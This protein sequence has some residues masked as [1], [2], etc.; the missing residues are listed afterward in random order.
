MINGKVMT[1]VAVVVVALASLLGLVSGC[2]SKPAAKRTIT[3]G[4]VD[5]YS[6]PPAVYT[7]DVRD[8]FKLAIDKVNKAGTLG[9]TI[10]Y[11]TRDDKFQPDL[12]LSMAKQLV[13]QDKVDI[14]MGTINSASSLAISNYAKTQKIPFIVTFSKSEDITGKDGHR[15]VFEVSENTAMVGKATADYLAKQPYT[16][17]WIAG[18]DYDYGHA[19]ANDTWNNLAALKPGVKLLGQTWWKVGEPDFTPYITAILAAKPDALIVATGGADMASFM[20]AAATTQLNQKIPFFLHTAIELDT[21][22]PL[23]LQAP[24]GVWGTSNYLFYYPNT[25]A[26]QAF[27][28]DFQAAYNRY[29]GVGAL[30]GYLAAQYITQAVQKIGTWDT[31]KFINALEGMQVDSPVGTVQMR[32]YDHQAVLPIFMGVTTKDPRYPF[33]IATNLTTIPGQDLMPSIDQIKAERAAAK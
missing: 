5:S 26:N 28:S 14:L 1:V 3:V 13:M 2:A 11:T 8:A 18:D 24:E 30:Y 12:A 23:G 19:I 9:T 10:A 4:I 21:L 22:K 31:E 27:V 15:Y 6:G 33:L 29:P 20:K 25:P 32:A 16:T 7:D 17:Y